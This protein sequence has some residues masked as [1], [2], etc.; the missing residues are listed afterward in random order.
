MKTRWDKVSSHL[1]EGTRIHGMISTLF[2]NVHGRTP[3]PLLKLFQPHFIGFL[4]P[5]WNPDL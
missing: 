1:S 4:R 2:K 3:K 5:C